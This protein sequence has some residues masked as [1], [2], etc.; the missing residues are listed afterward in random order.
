MKSKSAII[1]LIFS[2]GFLT[3]AFAQPSLEG[4][5]KSVKQLYILPDTTYTA[6]GDDMINMVKIINK[7]HFATIVQADSIQNS[8]FNGGE[9]TFRGNIYTEHLKYFSDPSL[10]GKSFSFK[11]TIKG[12][13]WTIEGPI[14]N[15]GEEKPVWKIYEEY[16]RI[17]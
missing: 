5:W 14:E 15:E 12:D 10:I 3:F 16:I 13:I 1:T 9:Y 8:M 6:T 11:S 7:T 4:T 17:K 2:L